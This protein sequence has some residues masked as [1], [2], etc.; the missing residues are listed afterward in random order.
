MSPPLIYGKSPIAFSKNV[1]EEIE[2]GKP[3]KQALAIAYAIKRRAAARK[4]AFGGNIQKD[5]MSSNDEDMANED[6]MYESISKRMFLEE[7]DEEED[8][9]E[10]EEN[11]NPTLAQAIMRK[12]ADGGQVD[13]EK[14]ARESFNIADQLNFDALR[15]ENYSEAHALK[16]LDYDTTRSIKDDLEDEDQYGRNIVAAI[17]RKMKQKQQ[18]SSSSY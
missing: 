10:N 11:L 2:S 1:K 3:Q 18:N 16:Q 7:G 6:K 14:N 4:K 9:K 5:V 13:L 12:Y 17:R 8:E 15:K